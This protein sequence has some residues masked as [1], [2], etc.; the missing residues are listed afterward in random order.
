MAPPV[1]ER[2]T[3]PA[4]TEQPEAKVV[5]KDDEAIA[6]IVE[7]KQI[8]PSPSLVEQKTEVSPPASTP[9]LPDTVSSQPPEVIAPPPKPPPLPPVISEAKS[10]PQEKVENVSPPTDASPVTAEAAPLPPQTVDAATTAQSGTSR[11]DKRA[12]KRKGSPKV[13]QEPPPPLSPGIHPAAAGEIKLPATPEPQAEVIPATVPGEA[14]ASGVNKEAPAIFPSYESFAPRK[15]VA[16]PMRWYRENRR[17]VQFGAAAVVLL[18]IVI[19][20]TLNR[21]SSKTVTTSKNLMSSRA[22]SAPDVLPSPS[23]AAQPPKIATPS[24]SVALAK[25]SPPSAKPSSPPTAKTEVSPPALVIASPP[26][27]IAEASPAPSAVGSPPAIQRAAPHLS[28]RYV[29]VVFNR[30]ASGENVGEVERELSLNVDARDG[31][32]IDYRADPANPVRLSN[33]Q[34]GTDGAYTAEAAFPE[35]SDLGTETVIATPNDEGT[36]AVNFSGRLPNGTNYLLGGVLRPWTEQDNT[37]YQQLLAAR[38]PIEKL[39]PPPEIQHKSGKTVITSESSKQG[40]RSHTSAGSSNRSA[41]R[42]AVPPP[43][44]RTVPRQNNPAPT[45]NRHADPFQGT[46]P[47]G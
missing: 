45:S 8:E 5:E 30:N 14:D 40:S 33:G 34:L 13:A 32:V 43:T 2:L 25:A 41:P 31:Y 16:E 7:A 17:V 39:T 21:R 20:L 12:K 11:R 1:T 38:A 26:A 22:T 10:S 23:Q 47:G 3:V 36:I 37:H 24:A 9:K 6:E 19:P 42:A 29:G 15:T 35:T 44:I 4:R 46:N 28:G 27:V 18:A